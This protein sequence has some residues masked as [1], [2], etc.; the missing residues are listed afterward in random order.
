MWKFRVKCHFGTGEKVQ[1]RFSTWLLGRLSWTSDQND[2]NYFQSTSHPILP[3]KFL[4][5]GPFYSGEVQNRFQDD[6]CGGHLVFPIGMIYGHLVF[7]SGT[8]LTIFDHPDAFYQ[9]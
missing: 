3:I 6:N 4:V 9:V 7:L 5:N 1:N 8:I 2:F